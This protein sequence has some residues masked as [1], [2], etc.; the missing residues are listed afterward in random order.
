[1]PKKSA[2]RPLA[3]PTSSQQRDSIS[4]D[5]AHGLPSPA[6]A[7][8]KPVRVRSRPDNSKV[9]LSVRYSPEVVAYFKATGEGWQA[10]M[11]DVLRDYVVRQS[12]QL[13]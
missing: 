10:R 8:V 5:D 3:P 9:L 12:R 13:Y 7:P 6:A 1:M 11:D 4:Q 2:T